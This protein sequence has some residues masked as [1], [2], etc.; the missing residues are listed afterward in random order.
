MTVK[1]ADFVLY[2]IFSFQKK[3]NY[4]GLALAN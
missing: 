4:I 3:Y 2:E 1:D